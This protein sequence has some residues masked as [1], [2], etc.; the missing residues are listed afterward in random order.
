MRVILLG[1]LPEYRKL[2]IEGVFYANI[3]RKGMELGHTH[4]EASWILDNNA[5]MKKG[6][7]NAGMKPYKRYRMYEKLLAG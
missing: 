4:G 3:L 2:G 1:V 7:E 6:V 5:M